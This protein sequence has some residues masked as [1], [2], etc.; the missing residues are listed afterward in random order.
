MYHFTTEEG[1][2]GIVSSGKLNPSIKTLTTKDAR[3]GS[4]QYLTD[5]IPGSMSN[6][7]LSYQLYGVPWNAKKV[8]NYV[9]ID[10][11]GLNLLKGRD[12]VYYVPNSGPLDI[13]DII[14]NYG[15]VGQ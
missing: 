12:G 11:T 10:T 2:N 5:I 3:M 6:G 4:G 9:E 7:K 8:I 14:L 13:T 15:K 1:L